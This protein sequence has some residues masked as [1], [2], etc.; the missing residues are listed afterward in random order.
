VAGRRTSKLIGNGNVVRGIEQPGFPSKGKIRTLVE[1][2]LL[3]YSIKAESAI[4]FSS[5][6][7]SKDNNQGPLIIDSV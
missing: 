7:Y 2:W 3:V 5:M 1:V 6:T 4:Y